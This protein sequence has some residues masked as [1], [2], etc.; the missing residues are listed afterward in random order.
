M[1]KMIPLLLLLVVLTA[2]CDL[3]GLTVTTTSE[4]PVI[5]SF[6]AD[7]PAI[8]AGESSTLSWNVLGATKVSIDQGV[9][10]VALNGRR[11][12]MRSETA[13]YTLTAPNASGMS[14]TPPAQGI[15][16]VSPPP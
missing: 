8:A 4:S 14:P 10:N 13:G 12:V 1:K 9:G 3:T 2:G 16:T 11:A 5:S 15:L 6:G 7:P